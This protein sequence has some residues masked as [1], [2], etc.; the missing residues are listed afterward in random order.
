LHSQDKKFKPHFKATNEDTAARDRYRAEGQFSPQTQQTIR[1]IAR[2]RR[3]SVEEMGETWLQPRDG[4]AAASAAVP[5]KPPG[6]AEAGAS[7]ELELEED[8]ET[9]EEELFGREGQVLPH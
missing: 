5:L 4:A 2:L 8:I 1:A 7:S 6:E 3:S 9:L